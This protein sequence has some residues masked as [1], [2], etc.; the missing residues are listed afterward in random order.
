MIRRKQPPALRGDDV[1]G[2]LKLH[3]R[4]T[5]ARLA[6]QMRERG[7]Q[8]VLLERAAFMDALFQVNP[9]GVYNKTFLRDVVT[10]WCRFHSLPWTTTEIRQEAYALKVLQSRVLSTSRHLVDGTRLSK[11]IRSMSSRLRTTSDHSPTPTRRRLSRK[12]SA[13]EAAMAGK[14]SREAAPQSEDDIFRL[15]GLEPPNAGHAVNQDDLTSNASIVPVDS[16]SDSEAEQY[17]IVVDATPQPSRDLPEATPEPSKTCTPTPEPPK[18][19]TPSQA[20]RRMFFDPVKQHFVRV[21]ATGQSEIGEAKPDGKGFMLVRWPEEDWQSTDHTELAPL[22][23]AGPRLQDQLRRGKG[24]AI[25]KKPAGACSKRTRE[26]AGDSEAGDDSDDAKCGSHVGDNTS[27][28]AGPGNLP[29]QPNP[30]QAEG[31]RARPAASD[32][33]TS[34][35]PSGSAS[36]AHGL[37]RKQIVKSAQDWEVWIVPRSSGKDYKV[38]YNTIQKT[39]YRTLTSAVAA[40]FSPNT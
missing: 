26:D 23:P 13:E 1:L 34:S 18:A 12:T 28:I 32:V 10:Q 22:P 20:D 21:C 6:V 27:D 2:I 17:P 3:W 39:R 5:E 36:V 15:Y 25:A 8:A 40:G 16:D 11:T 29:E 37:G 4:A 35:V 19:C 38:W 14:R 7:V 33:G 30:E 24:S 31:V 9:S